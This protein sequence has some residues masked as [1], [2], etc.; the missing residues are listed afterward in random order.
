MQP[1]ILNIDTATEHAS[2]C[3]S[4]G[5]AILGLLESADQKNHGAFLQP[6]IQQLMQ[7][8]GQQLNHLDAIAVTE[9]PGSYTGLRVG[10][11][12]AK[13]LC[14]ALQKPLIAINTLKVIALAAKQLVLENGKELVLNTLF[15]PMIDAR[16]MEVF[17]AIY[18][19]ELIE[20]AASIAKILDESAFQELLPTHTMVFSGSGAIKFQSLLQHPNGLFVQSQHNAATLAMLSFEA[21]EMG[22]FANLAYCEPFYGKAFYSPT[23]KK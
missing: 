4:R 20:T 18:N 11:A 23:S 22:V 8:S 12:S 13:G 19:R 17:T 14:Y 10:M 15:C 6:A 5:T 7:D 9:G 1:L 3:L 16:R 2:I 21:F